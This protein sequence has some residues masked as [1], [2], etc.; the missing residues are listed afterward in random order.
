MVGRRQLKDTSAFIKAHELRSV[1]LSQS[2]L[3]DMAAAADVFDFQND[4]ELQMEIVKRSS[5]VKYM[6]ESQADYSTRGA[7]AYPF[8]ESNRTE[9]Y[10]PRV[11]AFENAGGAIEP[12]QETSAEVVR[13]RRPPRASRPWGKLAAGAGALVVAIATAVY[14]A[15]QVAVPSVIGEEQG[16]ARVTLEQHNLKVGKIS[17]RP[18][19]EA[20]PGT[21]LT[22][23]PSARDR[24]ARGTAVD[25]VV[26][27]VPRVKVPA[28]V[29]M[30]QSTAVDTLK[31]SKLGVGT[32][33][34]RNTR[35]VQPGTVLAQRPA[36]GD[37]VAEGTPI[38]LIVSIAATVGAENRDDA[39]KEEAARFMLGAWCMENENVRAKITFGGDSA[40][41]IE[42]YNKTRRQRQLG[43]ELIQPNERSRM[44]WK[45]K[46]LRV[47]DGVI[48]VEYQSSDAKP[49]FVSEYERRGDSL[50]RIA[51]VREGKRVDR[52]TDVYS[53]C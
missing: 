26:A 36:A 2:I 29:R 49:Q 35:A 3:D 45:W 32:V 34:T 30:D 13:Q 6:E 4:Q 42:I 8:T 50:V 10:G 9:L 17:T 40:L 5:T 51:V 23:Q 37:E 16:R 19:T 52:P 41:R 15:M 48:Q 18:A 39:L 31:R 14:F 25:L 24:V 21:V 22:Q 12:G 11:A 46:I 38:D 28:V 47:A 27:E 7:F 1:S 44:D 33:T 53:R 43:E 20:R